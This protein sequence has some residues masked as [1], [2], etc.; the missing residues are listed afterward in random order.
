MAALNSVSAKL[1]RPVHPRDPNEHHRVSTPLELLFDLVSV[2]AIAS[3]AAG[4]HHAI[5][6]G[7]GD[8]AVVL[9]KAGA[10]TEKKDRDGKLA[11]E[12]APDAKV[13]DYV[14]KY[15]DEEGI[16]MRPS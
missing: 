9:L 7:N 11:I 14:M 10:E 15:A 16:N 5:A 4:L 13:R 8:T 2:I 1:L 6:E 12:L 3:A